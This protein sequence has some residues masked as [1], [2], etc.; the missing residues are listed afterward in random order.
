MLSRLAMSAL[1][2]GAPAAA[3]VVRVGRPHYQPKHGTGARPGTDR[4]SLIVNAGT[5]PSCVDANSA[6]IPCAVNLAYFGG[7]VLSNVKVYAVFWT[8]SVSPAVQ[9]GMPGFYRA[10]L[11]SEW[12]DWLSEYSTDIPTQAGSRAG[13]AG[14]QQVIGRGAFAGSFTLTTFS[15]TFPACA[16]P[17][18][19][20]TCLADADVAREI[21]WQLGHGNLPPPDANTVYVVNFPT[22]IRISDPGNVSCQDF[23][24]YHGAY[25]NAAQQSVLYT[26]MPELGANGC[27][28]GCGDGST[29][30]NTC[31]ATSHEVAESIT[32]G[33]AALASGPDFPLAWYDNTSP[34]QGEI[35]D[36]CTGDRD[37]VG[38]QGLTGC[39]AA[40]SGCYS[41]QQVFSRVVWKAGAALQPNVPACVASRYDANDYSLALNPNTLSLAPGVASQP[42]PVLTVLSNGAGQALTLSVT[43]V[44]VGLHATLDVPRLDVGGAAHLR[45]TADASAA[46]L[47]DGVLVVRAS[48]ATTHSAALLV[49]IDT[50][51]TVSIASP[52]AGT[53]V[54]GPT[55]VTV[56]TTSGTN[57]SIASIAI[58]IDAYAP[59]SNGLGNSTRWDTRSV[60]NGSHV[61]NVTVMDA[62]GG[63]ASASLTVTVQNVGSPG[64]VGSCSSTGGVP[65]HL[66]ALVVL[67]YA[68]RRARRRGPEP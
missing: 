3:D 56:V 13:Q 59:L 17:D 41:V 44:P 38:T 66:A 2:L 11:D 68:V 55:L 14:T 21:D 45:V 33:D 23:C 5:A 48:G 20:L 26:V 53:T 67:G 39:A 47:K 61:V 42:I 63:R 43:D 37:T 51:P 7:R 50:L 57:T 35:G 8:S 36:M 24:A 46:P 18:G 64:I 54:T 10:L 16:P 22:S 40:A 27:E 60:Q 30:E 25:Q 4:T 19:A 29:F 65:N 1:L 28:T 52:A 9:S 62:D 31:S 58:A 49:Q 32:D 6:P 12:M 34:S 15:K